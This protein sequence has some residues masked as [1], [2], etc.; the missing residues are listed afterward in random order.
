MSDYT[1]DLENKIAV[2]QKR[3]IEVNGFLHYANQKS[4]ALI[5]ALKDIS[6]DIMN[7]IS[8]TDARAQLHKVETKCNKAIADF[9]NEPKE[10]K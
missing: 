3:I 6:T 7:P 10:Q 1:H 8:M 2:L 9:D 4:K 5:E